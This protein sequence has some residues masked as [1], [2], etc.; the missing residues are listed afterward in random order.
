MNLFL[1][2]WCAVL[3]VALTLT[4]CSHQARLERHL[5]KARAHFQ[6]QRYAEAAIEYVNVLQL[7]DR[8]AEA[9]R[10]AGEAYFA[11]QEYVKA[12]PFLR[13][14]LTQ[15]PDAADLRHKVATI[16][17]LAGEYD[18][19]REETATLLA[20]NPHDLDALALLTGVAVTPA[21]AAEV[22][23]RLTAAAPGVTDKS[24]LELLR[25]QLHLR[26]Q[27]LAAAEQAFLTAQQLDPQA[28]QPPLM[29]GSLYLKQGQPD[30]AAQ[31]FDTALQIAPTNATVR[32][33]WA[34]FKRQTGELELSK[35]VLTELTTHGPEAVAAWHRLA[36]IAATE[37][38]LDE[39]EK[40]LRQALQLSAR[41]LPALI[42]EARLMLARGQTT[43]AVARLEKLSAE[44]PN[45][46]D[47]HHQLALAYL[48][49]PDRPKAQAALQRA[50]AA[51]PTDAAAALLA[52]RLHISAG[53]PDAAIALLE[54][55]L[56]RYPQLARGHVTLGGAYLAA[57]RPADAVAAFQS[58][59]ERQPK[60]NATVYLLGIARLASGDRAGALTAFEQACALNPRQHDALT[61]IIELHLAANNADAALDRLQRHDPADP[62]GH[63]L[64]G[65]VHLARGELADAE[66]AWRRAAE[67]APTDP[68][69]LQ[70]LAQLY[71]ATG[72]TNDAVHTIAAA[73]QIAPDDL[74]GL[75]LAGLIY[76]HTA[77]DLPRARDAL[78]RG[79][80]LQ[81]NAAP[82]AN[83]LALV[84]LELG[85]LDP[86]HD[87]AT[88]AYKLAPENPAFADTLGWIKYHRGEHPAAL[89]LIQITARQLGDQP[90]V[91]Y[92]L[93]A[94]QLALGD[95][96]AARRALTIAANN[97]TNFPGQSVA[98]DWLAILD[99]SADPS[100]AARLQELHHRW[101]K[102]PAVLYRLARIA[103][104]AG[105]LADARRWYE[106]LLAANRY[107]V[108][109]I[110]A[111]AGLLDD[112][113]AAAA[114]LQRARDAAP[115]DP[116][117]ILAHARLLYRTGKYAA[118]I[119]GFELALPKLPTESAAY[120]E[121]AHAYYYAGDRSRALDTARRA[122]AT[123]LIIA[124][125]GDAP[126]I[127]ELAQRRPDYLPARVALA[128]Q[129]IRARQFADAR[130]ICE[131]LEK[132]TPVT[133]TLAEALYGEGRALHEAGQPAAARPL[134]ERALQLHPRSP[135]AAGAR[136]LLE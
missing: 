30:R 1:F 102:Q 82:F 104:Q 16:Y 94:V 32:L 98:R 92:H 9:T 128:E 97:P 58:A 63:L 46:A 105:Q 120:A 39:A 53:A 4:G 28:T 99:L 76:Q 125:T 86:A 8:H 21:Q 66:T 20:R 70:S 61:R 68:T 44:Y 111:L 115:D 33:L 72:R 100:A 35:K 34:D 136:A 130:A 23:N 133:T 38:H 65:R 10:R 12:F 78:E 75:L 60:D 107:H 40:C 108:P 14:A 96:T 112:P 91:Q 48:R 59:V 52:A 22:E 95:E 79:L 15:E 90:E 18:K 31:Q 124:L 47:L 83:N 27:N 135:Q 127:T 71:A 19:V 81:P 37:G 93:G 25:G 77:G 85:N 134:L 122:E 118:A 57:K 113:A 89:D 50:L 43:E 2:R 119:T 29:L 24:R 26:Q 101:P 41:F 6:Q 126:A 84:H 17:Y 121:L 87:L 49:V 80:A 69:G 88:R 64:R 5:A 106:Q 74:R 54:P 114:L 129:A 110:V 123:D 109:A 51:D 103:E 116:R 42:L 55:L 45:V 132:V 117:L 56:R 62:A 131:P 36:E 7:N 11:R 3:L 73:L 67:L 13:Q